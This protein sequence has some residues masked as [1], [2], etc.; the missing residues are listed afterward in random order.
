MKSFDW[1][2]RIGV[3][4]IASSVTL[5]WEWQ[6]VLPGDVSFH[7]ERIELEDAQA[8]EEFLLAMMESPQIE[9]AS[10]ILGALDVDVIVFCCTIGSLIKG[11]GWDKELLTRIEKSSG[12]VPATSTS[13][14]LLEA[15]EHLDSKGV[16]VVTPYIDE[17]NVL[18]KR[19]L[20]DNGF[21]VTSLFG[22]QCITDYDIARV[23]PDQFVDAVK[24]GDSDDADCAF[25]SCTN[26]NTL[27]AINRLE[28]ETGKPVLSSNQVS[29]L[30]S[31][32]KIGYPVDKVQDYG[33]IFII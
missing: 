4:Y 18:E 32:K 8:D 3:I 17:L 12:G 11:K 31:L 13:T 1:K 30:S 21:N 22:Y 14:G 28:E 2:Y 7:V 9:K 26:S 20:E 27:E 10:K 23:T 19:F 16:N 5:E 33:K 29:L 24:K 25:I 15:L 6:N